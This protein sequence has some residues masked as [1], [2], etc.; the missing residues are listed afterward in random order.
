MK[1][2]YRC[3]SVEK[4]YLYGFNNITDEVLIFDGNEN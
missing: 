2:T 4:W 1:L 3:E